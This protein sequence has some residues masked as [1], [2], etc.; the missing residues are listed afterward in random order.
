MCSG[1]KQYVPPHTH[2]LLLHPHLPRLSLSLPHPP[3]HPITGPTLAHSQQQQQHNYFLYCAK[4]DNLWFLDEVDGCQGKKKSLTCDVVVDADGMFTHHNLLANRT[5]SSSDH[6]SHQLTALSVVSFLHI[7]CT[8]TDVRAEV[9][10]IQVLGLSES[11]NHHIW[12]DFVV[13]VSVSFL[14]TSVSIRRLEMMW[15]FL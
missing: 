10:H 13:T 1:Y 8:L 3:T 4:T 2:P 15:N 7:C 6:T 5:S 12:I 11:E 14:S 9:H